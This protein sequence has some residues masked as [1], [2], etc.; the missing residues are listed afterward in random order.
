MPTLFGQQVSDHTYELNKHMVSPTKETKTAARKAVTLWRTE[1]EYMAAVFQ[2]AAWEALRE[3]AFNLLLHIPNENS[4][5]TPG[6]KG[7]MPDLFLAVPRGGKAG[8]FI[9]L[10]IAS[11]KPSQKQL[12]VIYGLRTAGYECHII[13]DSVDEVITCITAY[14][15]S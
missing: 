13:W 15:N 11:G 1:R 4:H 9:E 8:L 3:P 6:V 10:K 7:G 5:K 12:D 2:A 14:L